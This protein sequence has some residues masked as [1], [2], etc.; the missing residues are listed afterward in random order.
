MTLVTKVRATVAVAAVVAGG[1]CGSGGAPTAAPPP[2]AGVLQVAGT[3][4]IVQRA[5]SSSCNDSGTPIP[6]T[7]VVTHAPGAGTFVLADSGGTTF[8]GTVQANGEFTANA[9][10]G[11]D[12]QGNTFTQRLAGRF[13]ATGFAARLEVDVTPRACAFTRD[14]TATKQGAP[15][16]FP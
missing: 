6:V 10:F 9:V 14:W 12:A 1:A 4:Q 15:N 5:V 11:P 13:A 7:G 16:V 8:N 3:Y 2:Q